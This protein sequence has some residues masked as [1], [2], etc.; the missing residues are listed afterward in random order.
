MKITIEE[1][2]ALASKLPHSNVQGTLK[3]LLLFMIEDL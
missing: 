1:G 2:I 3:N